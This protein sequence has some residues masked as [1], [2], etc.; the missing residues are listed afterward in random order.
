[1]TLNKLPQL[2]Q[3]I[4]AVTFILFFGL[5]GCADTPVPV[6]ESGTA[7][8]SVQPIIVTGSGS[9]PSG[10]VSDDE[11]V[12]GISAAFSGPSEGL[13][14]ELYRGA[15]AYLDAVNAAGGVNGRQ[16]AV[17]VYDDGY[18]PTPAIDNTIQLVEQDD[19]FLLF[20]YVGTPTVTRVLPL[21]SRYQNQSM[22]LFFPFT[23]AQPQREQPYDSYVF[24]LRTSY[25]RET[26]G[27]V[28]NFISL[29][30][31]Q[32]AV[33]Y[34][35]DAY[36]RSGWDGVKR[37]LDAYNLDIVGE[38]TYHR[39]DDFLHDFSPQ[40]EILKA[41]DADA[42]ILIGSYQACAGFI[43]DAR[44]TGWDVPLANVS[45]VGSESLLSLLQEAGQPSARD[46]TANLINSQVVPS[47]L[48]TSLP[49]V[50]EYR[51]LIG[52][53]NPG[54]LQKVLEETGYTPLPYSYVSFEGFLNAK[55]LV[56]ILKR[57]GENPRRDHI[58]EVV[59]AMGEVDLGID[60]P[61]SFGPAKHQGLDQVYYTT[62]KDGRFVTLTDWQEWAK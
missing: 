20:N 45:F 60:V 15:M 14:I 52:Q 2:R 13:G 27:L 43:R 6:L 24:N 42:V 9:T 31:K 18:N 50:R 61:A 35:A 56:E 3:S 37:A 1:M 16:I 34:Q 10:G 30:R 5:T 57:M 58:V 62:V 47:Y 19:V 54:P 48:D 25:R 39:G 29:G 59:E 49:S 36:G 22:Y 4:L 33:F 46:Y 8:S 51:Q 21:L 28:D 7:E 41:A 12:I 40:V 53:Y 23:G 38:A 17:R 55:L 44:N 32:V 26:A 11:I